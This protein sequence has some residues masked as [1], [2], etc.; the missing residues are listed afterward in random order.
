MPHCH[1]CRRADGARAWMA[2]RM[3]LRR[4]WGY[5]YAPHVATR[6]AMPIRSMT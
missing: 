5:T 1:P 6:R 3:A 2:T 4:V